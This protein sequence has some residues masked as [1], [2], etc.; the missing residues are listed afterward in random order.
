MQSQK[1]F[2]NSCHFTDEFQ[3]AC[4][5]EF[6]NLQIQPGTR[7]HSVT[8]TVRKVVEVLLD[9]G[10]P[11]GILT[12]IISGQSREGKTHFTLFEVILGFRQAVAKIEEPVR[13]FL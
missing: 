12:E 2:M 9:R 10:C 5:Q 11:D 8:G 6:L 4:V 7:I 1:I 13:R 3:Q